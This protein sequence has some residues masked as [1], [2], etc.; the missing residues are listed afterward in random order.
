MNIK[1]EKENK[2]SFETMNIK[3]TWSTT[4]K[5]ERAILYNNYLYR[6]RCKNQNSSLIYVCTS[7]SCP[8]VITLKNNAIIKLNC[9]N[10]NHDPKLIKNVQN[11]L[12][13]LQR[14]ILTD[15][16]QTIGKINEEEVKKFVSILSFHY[17]LNNWP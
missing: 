1:D 7:K 15:V 14:R 10:R 8:C 12:A 3:F 11:I 16:N 5:G 2:I 9:T 13:G 17:T 6:L 4:Q